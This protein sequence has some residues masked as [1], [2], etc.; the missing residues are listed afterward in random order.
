MQLVQPGI[1]K[2]VDEEEIF[3]DCTLFIDFFGIYGLAIHFF[4]PLAYLFC[5]FLYRL[6]FCE[7]KSSLFFA[8][9]W[10]ICKDSPNATTS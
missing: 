5:F 4:I 3:A 9:R 8:R 10:Q 7:T 1:T 2:K 6:D